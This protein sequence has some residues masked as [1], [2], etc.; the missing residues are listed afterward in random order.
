MR[1]AFRRMACRRSLNMLLASLLLL[2]L[3]LL[4]A[5]C[6]SASGTLPIV[7]DP[8]AT[9]TPSDQASQQDLIPTPTPTDTPTIAPTQTQLVPTTTPTPRPTRTPTRV[10]TTPPAGT[11]PAPL[12]TGSVILVSLNAQQ[13][14]AYQDG[15]FVF[16]NLVETGRPEL[17][18][19]TGTYHIFYKQCSDLRWTTNAGPTSQHN[20]GCQHNGDG[21]QMVFTS[22]WPPGSPNYYYPTHINYGAE[23]L[24]GGFYLHD[25]WW[26]VKFGPGSNVPHQLPNGTWE[27]GSHGCVGMTTADAQRLYIWAPSGTTVIVR[28]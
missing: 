19:P 11:P 15:A 22:P 13:L 21:Y 7:I 2:L 14:W 10:A 3:A 5:A 23:F 16:T 4:V 27:T 20:P 1:T 26:H 6:S 28:T 24:S 9:Q 17:P 12:A 18:T 25:A 8:F